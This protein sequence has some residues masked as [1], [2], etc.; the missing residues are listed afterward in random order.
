M[1]GRYHFKQSFFT[2]ELGFSALTVINIDLQ[3]E[4]MEDASSCISQG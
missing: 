3:V 2:C 4:P 1:A